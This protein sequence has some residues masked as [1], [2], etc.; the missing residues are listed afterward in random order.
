[1]AICFDAIRQKFTLETDHTLYTFRILEGKYPLHLYYGA[2]P[3]PAC[4][5]R[6]TPCVSFSPYH[7]GEEC[8]YLPDVEPAEYVGFDSGDFRSS[9]LK[10]RN[11]NGDCVTC[12]TYKAHRIFDG[13]LTIPGIPCADGA[14]ET[15]ELELED[16]LT[17][18]TVKL[19][20]TLFCREDVISR[21]VKVENHGET[22]V[23]VEKCMSLLLDLPG[24]DYEMISLYG[25]HCFERNY[26][27]RELFHGIQSICSRR[28]ASSHQFNPFIAI[29][30]K[31]TDE[32]S[33][34]IYGFNL[35]WSGNFLDE[36]EVDQLNNTRVQ[37]G[38][39]EE[40]FSWQLAA[41]EEFVSPEAVM[42]F[43]DRGMGQMARNFHDFIRRHIMPPEPYEK[44]PVVLNTWEACFFD[45]DEDSLLRFADAAVDAGIDMLV[46]DDGWFGKRFRDNAALGDWY[47]N[48]DKF[49]DGLKA[50]VDRVRSRNIRFGIWI[51]PEMINPDSD[52]YRAHPEW[53]L[54]CRGRELMLSREQL[55]L[56]MGNPHVRQ[57]L[58]DVLSRT[59][60]D[61]P[62]DY[63]KWDFNRHL[64]QVGSLI[65]PPERQKE[66]SFRFMLGV[67]E[68]YGWF[69]KTW[70][71]AMLENC[72][73][74]GGRYDLA[75]MKYST[76][77]WTS[78]NTD[79]RARIGI[80]YSSMLAYPA[81]TMSCH[82]S[83]PRNVCD[84]PR[85]LKFR[86]EVAMGGALGYELHLPN[87][88]QTIK[89]TVKAQIGVYRKYEDLI[90]W[91]D[92][93]PVHN[94]FGDTYCAYYYANADRSRLLVSYLQWK[95]DV[96]RQIVISVAEA[97]E[98]AVYADQDGRTFTG[99]QLRQGL[100][101]TS[102]NTDNLSKLW[103]L[104]KQ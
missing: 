95:E 45:I 97:A 30:R 9:S 18:C 62:I 89:D 35:V 6:K 46:M 31:D 90:L 84:D 91:G 5:E 104:V 66:A 4:E 29:C 67:Y 43:T 72:S 54:Q 40:H 8:H 37:L 71:G 47:P 3:D 16:T 88:S 25:K 13:R 15:L 10:I 21:Y 55:L 20:Y 86:W 52:L 1:M 101:V 56:D 60:E 68:F 79:P 92:Y 39:G 11:V 24:C 28:G 102:D 58:K 59:F 74:G 14:D 96:P 99:T 73:G 22:A 32:V 27:R 48:G 82:V 36:V 81:A 94:P 64:S 17:R 83:N 53:C 61:I 100:T 75:M 26:Q 103:Y 12:L 7:G 76:M 42:T 50:F 93:F 69:K 78:D 38:L 19:Y 98:D 87:A 49:K 44:R 23:T 51:E 80:Q 33:G 85:E 63:F 34:D 57:Y 65:L 77:I 70:P 41:G 2:K